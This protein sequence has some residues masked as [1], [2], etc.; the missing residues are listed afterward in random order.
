MPDSPERCTPT[1]TRLDDA[2]E[3]II[4][5]PHLRRRLAID[6]EAACD[7]LGLSVTERTLLLTW[8]TEPG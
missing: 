6:P 1:R 4:G 8:L 7:A 2:V 5:D 3:A